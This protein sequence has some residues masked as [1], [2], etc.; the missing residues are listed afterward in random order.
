MLV[1]LSADGRCDSPGHCAQ[2]TTHTVM[3]H[4]TNDIL[5]TVV[6]DK[7]EVQ[8]KSPNMERLGLERALDELKRLGFHIAE[9][10][11]DAHIQVPPVL[12]MCNP[13]VCVHVSLEQTLQSNIF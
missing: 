10:V 12:G 13:G 3:E 11:T 4:N 5:C 7:R 9:V 1:Y 8:L 2:Y 6:V